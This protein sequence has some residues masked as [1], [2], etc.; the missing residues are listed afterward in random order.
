MRFRLTA[1]DK[2]IA[3]D[4]STASDGAAAYSKLAI[5]GSIIG[6]I[7]LTA[8]T[9]ALA[10]RTTPPDATVGEPAPRFYLRQLGGGELQL[11]KWSA[12]EHGGGILLRSGRRPRHAVVL[13]FFSTSCAPCRREMPEFQAL[14]EA[15]SA[16][17]P[18]LWRFVNTQDNAD[19]VNEYVGTLGVSLP[20][21]LDMYGQV[22][23]KFAGMPMRL[24]TTVVIDPHGVVRYLH[25]G[26]NEQEGLGGIARTVAEIFNVAVPE[27]WA[28]GTE[29]TTTETRMNP[30]EDSPAQSI[31]NKEE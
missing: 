26:Y 30:S 23:P 3:S 1:S 4:K 2:S 31:E 13:S 24:P 5:H 12:P 19:S 8:W 20:V 6:L 10:V 9:S 7:L 29:Q 27:R 16:D 28:G 11:S 21:I 22:T 14:S 17:L 15:F 25:H 18:I